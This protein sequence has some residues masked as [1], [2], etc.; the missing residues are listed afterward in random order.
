MIPFSWQLTTSTESR[1]LDEKTINEFGI[2]GYTLM[3]I[4]G[5]AMATDLINTLKR[6]QHVLVFCGKG[7]N[8]G[9]GLVIARYLSE[10]FH[11]VTV[12]FVSG[13][14]GLSPDAKK[15]Y[16]LLK[17]LKQHLDHDQEQAITFIEGWK[18][19]AL[20]SDYDVIIDAML[21]TGLDSELRGYYPEAVKW[22]NGSS[23]PAYA[24]DVPT[25]L[26]SD[27]GDVMGTSVLA[28]KTF[29]LGTRKLGCYLS[30]G[31]RV[32]GD[33]LH[34][35]LPFPNFLKRSHHRYL[36]DS[37]WVDDFAKPDQTKKARHKYEAGVLYIIAGSE[38]LT[39]AALMAARSA[40]AE[41][42]GAVILL[43]PRGIL[44][45]IESQSPQIIKKPIGSSD[46]VCF[47]SSHLSE[48]EQ[49]LSEKD[50]VVLMG[51][52]L[53]RD[54]STL[55]FVQQIVTKISKAMV[56]DADALFALSKIGWD[57]AAKKEHPVILTPHPGELKRLVSGKIAPDFE[58]LNTV[59][60]FSQMNGVYTLSKGNPTLF[61][62]PAG[63]SY[64]TGYDTRKFARAGFGD[65]LA[66]KIG[67]KLSISYKAIY[68]G[69]SGL[70]SG[71]KKSEKIVN[72]PLEPI[73][74]I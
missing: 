31:P 13:T 2:P 47:K 52:G 30:D 65:I 44:P 11:K 29:N 16:G 48:L 28:D 68:S 17:K 61:V 53:G 74:L 4:A 24:V 72:K 9:D 49:I 73:D 38:G 37:S 14:D 19:E 64:L 71:H 46:D 40:W 69:L 39:G 35:E 23:I 21:G 67:A 58:R 12:L 62:T 18:P 70:L 32:S 5:Y 1:N 8:G 41:G 34:C 25:G 3:E 56:L 63:T 15:N 66:G 7:N 57:W 26:N 20:T 33:V 22:M 42:I 27:T 10:H 60:E 50:G 36:I 54:E 51:P 55:T 59:E 6:G 43:T 45:V